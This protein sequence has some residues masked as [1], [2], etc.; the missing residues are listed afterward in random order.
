LRNLIIFFV[1]LS[2][3]F[4]VLLLLQTLAQ[5]KDVQGWNKARWGMTD[6]DIMK[7]FNEKV[8]RL[9]DSKKGRPL[10]L[11]AS[12]KKML[13][14]TNNINYLQ[15]M[16]PHH[17]IA[18]N[19]SRILLLHTKNPYMLEFANDIIKNQQYEIWNMKEALSKL[20]NIKPCGKMFPIQFHSRL[21]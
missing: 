14:N 16:I 17:Q 6:E 20:K 8:E 1:V 7:A 3:T 18:V 13:E 5:P 9:P 15:H 2:T 4:F 12:D 21:L 11:S 10:S 19:M